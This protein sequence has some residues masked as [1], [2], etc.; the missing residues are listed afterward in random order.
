MLQ[1]MGEITLGMV[2]KSRAREIVG[3]I[4]FTN[5][6]KLLVDWVSLE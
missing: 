2:L 5:V 3:L 4:S 1:F 6:R